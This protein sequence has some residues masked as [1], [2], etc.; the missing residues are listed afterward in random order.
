MP[1]YA[2]ISLIAVMINVF[3]WFILLREYYSSF[4]DDYLE[5]RWNKFIEF[6]KG[7]EN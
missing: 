2:W 7:G 6:E 3:L 4:E 5:E 1:W